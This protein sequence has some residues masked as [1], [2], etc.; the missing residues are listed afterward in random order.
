[1]AT[2]G[3]D[4]DNAACAYAHA[5][6][7]VLN[8]RRVQRRRPWRFLLDPHL[9]EILQTLLAAIDEARFT[10]R[11][12]QAPGAQEEVA[13]LA[14][15]LKNRD[16]ASALT[17]DSAAELLDI[18]NRTVIRLA[19]DASVLEMARFEV[20]ARQIERTFATAREAREWLLQ[21]QW[22]DAKWH[23]RRW[24]RLRLKRRLMWRFAAGMTVAVI[25]AGAAARWADA[26][27]TDIAVAVSAGALGSAVSGLFKLRDEISK[28]MDI[29]AF[30]AVGS[31]QVAVGAAAGIL[32]LFLVELGLL[33]GQGGPQWAW[34]GAVAFAAGFSEPFLLGT[35]RGIAQTSG[36]T[37]REEPPPGA[38][39]VRPARR[40][41]PAAPSALALATHSGQDD[42]FR[43]NVGIAVLRDGDVLSL[44]R[45]GYPGTWQMPQGGLEVGEEPIDAARRELE[46]ETG[47]RWN[48]VELLGIHPDWLVYELEAGDRGDDIG[49]GQVQKWFYVRLRDADAVVDVDRVD[50]RKG[51]PEF[52]RH[53]WM[54]FPE[55]VSKSVPFRRRVYERVA[56][57]ARTLA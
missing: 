2:D 51:T 44:E 38:S 8:S 56:E 14:A 19:D 16:D 28:G 9:I 12:T 43:A 17:R 27:L 34:I 1:M 50:E 37:R 6:E 31:A 42:F 4:F 33:G 45:Y 54:S 40:P 18:I 7:K 20:E 25:A 13:A 22:Q 26:A 46:E 15:T 11:R 47:L 32:V 55:L 35:V 39:E 24:T 10:A 57:H 41:S 48:Q 49:R 36:Q 29:V 53:A 3:T 30:A 21:A 23:R 5:L 52:S